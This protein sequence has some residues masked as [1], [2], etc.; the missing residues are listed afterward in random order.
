MSRYN[1]HEYN[2]P[3][4]FSRMH[5]GL[6]EGISNK[7]WLDMWHRIISICNWMTS[8]A[9]YQNIKTGP[10][11]M[12]ACN[13]VR[14]INKILLEWPV[15]CGLLSAPANN[16]SC[17]RKEWEFL[18]MKMASSW[19]PTWLALML[20]PNIS[21]WSTTWSKHLVRT[22]TV[23]SFSL[24]SHSRPSLLPSELTSSH[25]HLKKAMPLSCFQD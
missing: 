25:T 7:K 23:L 3:E 13:L 20:C 9:C 16:I 1:Y 21:R 17:S 24:T 18:G 15:G 4:N 11:V 2:F 22:V 12:L 14:I 10:E 19:W 8:G 5:T 6:H